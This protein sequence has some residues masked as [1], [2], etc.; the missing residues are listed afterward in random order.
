MPNRVLTSST[1]VIVRS[2]SRAFTIRFTVSISGSGS[3]QCARR[4]RSATATSSA[5]TG[6]RSRRKPTSW[7]PTRPYSLVVR[8]PTRMPHRTDKSARGGRP[9]EHTE[10]VAQ[11]PV[12]V[13]Q[14][15]DQRVDLG[16]VAGIVV[17]QP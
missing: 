4:Y 16:G 9:A 13:G 14:V 2:W 3:G 17:Q 1:L 11:H 12:E 5:E 10:P 8:T 6:T 7:I 15:G